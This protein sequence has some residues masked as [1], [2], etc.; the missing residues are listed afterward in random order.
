M[1]RT[2]LATLALLPSLAW[3]QDV[4]PERFVPF[5]PGDRWEYETVS[6]QRSEQNNGGEPA[7][8]TSFAVVHVERDTVIDGAGWTI[9]GVDTYGPDR[10]LRAQNECVGRYLRVTRGDRELTELDV[11]DGSD[12][13]CYFELEFYFFAQQNDDAEVRIGDVSYPVEATEEWVYYQ[14]GVGGS[15]IERV[16]THAADVGR[17]RYVESDVRTLSP[18]YS[19][20][21]TVRLLYAEVGGK[22]YGARAVAGAAPPAA[23]PSFTV[24]AFPNPGAGR[25]RLNV[26]GAASGPLTVEVVDVIG[27]SVWSGV[28]RP[29]GV[30]AD[31]PSAGW[32]PGL[33]VVRVRDAMGGA[34]TVRVTRL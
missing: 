1:T 4:A 28:L 30:V 27:R 17:V 31:V 3:S 24:A 6:V 10:T 23:P 25:L 22:T 29:F 20:R 33:Y 15:S 2:L 34:A 21:T 14:S 13:G 16:S 12:S 5:E 18:T 11:L 8:S 7:A 26:E 32:A 9:Y 19:R